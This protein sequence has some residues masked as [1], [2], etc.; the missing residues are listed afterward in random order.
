MSGSHS[1]VGSSRGSSPGSEGFPAASAGTQS[2]SRFDKAEASAAAETPVARSEKL[3]AKLSSKY[4]NHSGEDIK[5]ALQKVYKECNG[6]KGMTIA[7]IIKATSKVIESNSAAASSVS[8]VRMSRVVG[9]LRDMKRE[10]ARPTVDVQQGQFQRSWAPTGPA[11][12]GL[13]AMRWNGKDSQCSICLE[14]LDGSSKQMQTSCG[15]SFH[16]HCLE[17]WYKTD[18]S[19]PNCRTPSLS[20]KDF[21]SLGK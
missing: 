19:C 18:Q 21:P 20:D 6:L 9:T 11:G 2:A 13:E 16:E 4:P 10:S 3:F 17:K 1:S 15:H 12:N 14:D 8:V 5:A 7:Q